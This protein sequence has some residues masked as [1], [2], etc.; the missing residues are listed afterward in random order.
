[1]KSCSLR[2]SDLYFDNRDRSVEPEPSAMLRSLGRGV[3]NAL[4]QLNTAI[5]TKNVTTEKG[6]R[7]LR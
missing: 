5:E 7:I 4:D 6:A 2:Y 3:L 1:M